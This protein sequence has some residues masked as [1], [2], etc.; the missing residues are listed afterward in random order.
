MN[1]HRFVAQLYTFQKANQSGKCI[2]LYQSYKGLHQG[3]YN[4]ISVLTQMK[5]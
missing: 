1:L 3:K 2:A 4:L 5:I